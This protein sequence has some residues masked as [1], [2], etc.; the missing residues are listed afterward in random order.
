MLWWMSAR[1]HAETLPGT[2]MPPQ[3]VP[4]EPEAGEALEIVA[5]AVQAI[6]FVYGSPH[7]GSRYRS[8]FLAD[9]RLDPVTLRRSEDSFVDEIFADAPALGAPLLRALFPRVYLDAN[10]EPYELDPRMFEDELPRHANTT[11][12]R[13]LG[14]IGTIARVVANGAEIY[15]RKLRFAEAEHRI[16]AFYRPYHWALGK[17]LRD[18]RDRFG[19]AVLVDCHSMPSTGG[20]GDVDAG[21]S[22]TDIVLG[23]RFGTACAPTLVDLA[24]RVLTDFGYTVALNAPYAGGYSVQKYG[25]PHQ[26]VHALQIEINRALYMDEE[27]IERRPDIDRVTEHMTVLMATLRGID[28]ARLHGRG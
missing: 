7:S 5:P 26:G 1:R 24:K 22:R 4:S 11:S 3:A 2:T 28:R 18:T 27:R 25:R 9:S 6:P 17:L 23:N 20:P 8:E 13:V 12:V 14:G 10:R 21:R 16:A 19:C 15:R